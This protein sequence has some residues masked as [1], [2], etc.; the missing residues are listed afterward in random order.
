MTGLD[1]PFSPVLLTLAALLILAV[2]GWTYFR[3]RRLLRPAHLGLLAGIRVLAFLC[4]LLLLLNP[5]SVR[6]QPDSDGFRVAVLADASGSMETRDVRGGMASRREVIQE[7]LRNSDTPPFSV[8]ERE[9]YWMD[10]FRFSDHLVSLA[11]ERLSVLAGPTAIG[12]VLDEG[13]QRADAERDN[14]GAVLLIS[15]GHS[16]AGGSPM[17][18]ARRYRDRGIPVTTIGVGAREA[19][20]D[21][22][23]GFA[24]S[25]VRGERGESVD[26]PVALSN[27]R[28]AGATV[29]LRLRDD[30]GT[31]DRREVSLSPGESR[32]ETFSVTPVT[33]G[34]HLYR[35]SVVEEIDGGEA[36]EE[37]HYAFVTAEEPETFAVLY[38][39]NRL[40]LE[41]RFIE[42]AIAD[43]E[44][45]VMESIIR[46]GEASFFQA[47]SEENEERAPSGEFPEDGAFFNR[48]DAIL[49]DTRI[50]P[51]LPGDGQT[52]LA[53]FASV[54]GGGLLVFGPLGDDAD[55]LAA[56]LPV[57]HTDDRVLNERIRLE[58]EAAPIFDHL[59]GG[60]LFGRPSLFIDEDSPVG[61]TTEWKRGARPVL[62]REGRNEAI[63]TAQAFGAGRVAYIGTEGTWQWRMASDGGLEQHRLFWE[64]LL[65]WLSSTGKPRLT[66][67]SQGERYNLQE[68]FDLEA[69]VLGAD[70]RAARDAAV[71]VQVTDPAGETWERQLQPSFDVPGRYS[72]S[73]VPEEPGEYHAR[74]RVTFP[75]GE[76]MERDVYFI[77]GHLGTEQEDTRYRES[78]LRD[79]ARV[80]GGAFFHYSEVGRFSSL[81]LSDEIPMRESRRYW[82]NQIWFLLL[83]FAS[84]FAE[85]FFRRRLG[86]K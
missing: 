54:R 27:T 16:N 23:V 24:S 51:F 59:A 28:D 19:P 7:W 81:P 61:A 22:E 57:L 5:Y 44:Q 25:R 47:L 18:A 36:R 64:N 11:G 8:P 82:A 4:L 1:T 72:G 10:R 65:A 70:F 50:L 26:L 31:V 63:M 86:L 33:A 77:A 40:N 14:L 58:I 42:R 74:Y 17:D 38:L 45:I 32:E 20:G 73:Y 41:Y 75:G 3:L 52:A 67:S 69:D 66:V 84:L 29:R 53:D 78:L 60:R 48:Y 37:I 46:T 15:D 55:S 79:L 83:L 12:D 85:W 34:E 39:G 62:L 2:A 80:T 21:L 30:A 6:E 71:S 13:L 76:R 68:S 35:L 43:S 9:G 56:A 49:L